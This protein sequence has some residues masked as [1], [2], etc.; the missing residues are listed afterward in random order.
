MANYFGK[1]FHVQVFGQSHAPA[2]GCVI[3][4]IPA[5]FT[6]DWA[7]ISA[8]MDRRAP[9]RS[10]FSTSRKEADEPKI[11]SG[12]NEKGE[13]CGAPLSM[14]IENTDHHSSDYEKLKDIPR[15]GHADFSA[16]M[17]FRDAHD[18]RGGGAF[19]GRMTAPLCFAGALA[20]QLLEKEGIRIK[21]QI[22]SIGDVFDELLN[23]ADPDFSCI[24]D[25][26]FPVVN[27]E[28]NQ[29][30][31][32]KILQAKTDGDSVGGVLCCYATG[33]PSGLGNPMFEGVENKISQALFAIPGVRGVE[34]GTGFAAA[35][36]KGSQH[37]DAFVCEDNKV[38]TIT[39]HHGGVLGGITTGMPL[40]VKMAVK[41][42]PSISKQQQSFSISEGKNVPLTVQGRHDPCIVPRAVPVMEAVIACVLYDL[43]LEK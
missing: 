31:Q 11:L 3:E 41:P 25:D 30:M 33:L 1:H 14:C 28:A 34:F 19:S 10:A 24:T 37:N 13:T 26:A 22:A 29:S 27:E 43:F 17:K 16:Y 21:A 15:P 18:I 2:I 4:G 35:A 32:E 39:N 6:P 42:T 5:G 20:M 40:V 7:K 8:F 38:K 9:G 36:L 12:L 23:F